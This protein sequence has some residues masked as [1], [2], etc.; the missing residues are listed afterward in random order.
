MDRFQGTAGVIPIKLDGTIG[1]VFSHSATA[2]TYFYDLNSLASSSWQPQIT[3]IGNQ[4]NILPSIY[5]LKV[6]SS[7]GLG[8]GT[9][10]V[11]RSFYGGGSTVCLPRPLVVSSKYPFFDSPDSEPGFPYNPQWIY[12][13]LD[14]TLWVSANETEV[15]IWRI[16][17]EF[18]LV[19]SWAISTTRIR[20]LATDP[21]NQ[22][23]Y[24]ATTDGLF[25]INV[26]TDTVTQLSTDSCMAVDVGFSG[27]VFAAFTDR[28]ASSLNPSWADAHSFTGTIDFSKVMFIRCDRAST[29][30]NLAVLELGFLDPDDLAGTYSNRR[31]QSFA[32]IHWWNNT[33]GYAGVTNCTS[34]TG[35]SIYYSARILYPFNSSFICEDG[36]WIYA[37]YVNN[38]NTG[39]SYIRGTSR[40]IS[41]CL[42]ARGATVVN[43][44]GSLG[45]IGTISMA[46]SFQLGAA[47]FNQ[48]LGDTTYNNSKLQYENQASFAYL[49]QDASKIR[50][51]IGGYQSFQGISSPYNSNLINQCWRDRT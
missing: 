44:N 40:H 22:Y 13:W 24:V 41:K 23:I 30:Y 16:Y 20:D 47:N 43:S 14:E 38:N 50:L 37:K 26:A 33:G 25:S 36:T 11:Y 1:N 42:T 2:N 21:D 17:P 19:S 35:S 3:D 15:G 49:G 8:I 29:D 39:F 6:E 51:C 45:N 12:K 4:I 5:A 31:D 10:S 32:K 46:S 28:L 48:E 9:Y 27:A 34:Q 7:G 18:E